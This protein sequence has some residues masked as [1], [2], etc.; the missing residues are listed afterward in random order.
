MITN[1]DLNVQ[2]LSVI[3]ARETQQQQQAREARIAEI[4]AAI[5]TLQDHV[6]NMYEKHTITATKAAKNKDKGVTKGDRARARQKAKF[7]G[8]LRR[9]DIQPAL[10]GAEFATVAEIRAA[11]IVPLHRRASDE[12]KDFWKLRRSSWKSLRRSS[13]T[14]LQLPIS[15]T[16]VTETKIISSLTCSSAM[17]KDNKFASCGAGGSSGSATSSSNTCIVVA[18]AWPA[19][20]GSSTAA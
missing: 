6:K 13:A 20:R 17:A 5:R 19:C 7:Y 4:E 1:W 2:E 14:P 18:P 11:R 8:A 10:A 15:G 9:E 12:I 3:P 16:L